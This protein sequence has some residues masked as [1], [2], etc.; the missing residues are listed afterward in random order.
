MEFL[1]HGCFRRSGDPNPEGSEC[2]PPIILP[3]FGVIRLGGRKI[4]A[5]PLLEEGFS[6]KPQ[7][8]TV[9]LHPP[10]PPLTM[11]QVQN[12]FYAM[13]MENEVLI[14]GANGTNAPA[15]FGT[16]E[17]GKWD[18]NFAMDPTND[19]IPMDIEAWSSYWN[20]L[21]ETLLLN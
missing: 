19:G 12:D 18:F 14:D 15:P 4:N 13:K 8:T 16:S 17:L 21:N 1:R 6:P 5:N 3:Y 7:K 10:P 9:A 2:L 11:P 20:T